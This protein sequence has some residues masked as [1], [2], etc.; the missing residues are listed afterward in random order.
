MLKGFSA[1]KDKRKNQL[2]ELLT[3]KQKDQVTEI[4]QKQTPEDYGYE[5]KFWTT[6]ILGRLIEEKFKVK[7]K[8]KTSLYLIFKRSKFTY[9]KPG[10]V[11]QKRDEEE[12]KQW[13][14]RTKP[15]ITKVINDPNTII[16]CEDEMVLS[17]QT[18]IQKVWLPQGE[19]PKIEFSNKKENRSIYGFL[20]IK[21]GI[22]HAFKTVW[23]NMHITADILKNIRKIYPSK[24][25]LLL[26]DGPGWHKGSVVTE[27]IKQDGHIKII[28][29]PKYSP[30]ENP[31]EHIWKKGRSEITHNVMIDDIDETT[32]KFVKY[33]NTNKFYYSLLGFSAKS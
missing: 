3:N 8:S 21:T 27:F 32:N 17:T 30:E 14:I 20:N 2:K 22:E 11:Y 29:F 4:L 7:Y 13:E 23:Q 1:I 19:Y 24:D 33:L 25:I 10:R 9:H 31:Q 5:I 15:I 12:V 28:H 18:T 26:W 16:L 6:D